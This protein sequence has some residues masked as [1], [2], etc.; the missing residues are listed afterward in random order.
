M[1][2]LVSPLTTLADVGG[3][4]L[5]QTPVC[6]LHLLVKPRT[7]TMEPIVPLRPLLR[8]VLKNISLCFVKAFADAFRVGFHEHSLHRVR[9]GRARFPD[10]ISERP[11]APH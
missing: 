5:T 10:T 3:N 2:R 7:A 8:E 11:R 6:L 9:H 1:S 4:G